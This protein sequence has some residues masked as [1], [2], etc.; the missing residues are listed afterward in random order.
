MFVRC[1]LLAKK[2]REHF[3]CFARTFALKSKCVWYFIL[4]TRAMIL[5]NHIEH[6]NLPAAK[7]TWARIA[8][9]FALPIGPRN[10]VH[11]SSSKFGP[12]DI[13][14]SASWC[15]W[16]FNRASACRANIF[17]KQQPGQWVTDAHLQRLTDSYKVQN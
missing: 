10:L 14:S 8:N 11:E 16:S 9:K 3:S 4:D 13:V 5:I 6:A 2:K 7:S 17:S 12:F 1:G 15:L